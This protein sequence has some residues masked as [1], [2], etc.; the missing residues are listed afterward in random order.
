MRRLQ[1]IACSICK[2]R[3]EPRGNKQV[4]CSL[5]CKKRIDYKKAKEKVKKYFIK[6]ISPNKARAHTRNKALAIYDERTITYDS[7]TG[8]AY[9]G[10]A[11]RPLMKVDEGYGFKGV[12]LQTD[13]RELVQCHICG[14]WAKVIS[15]NHLKKHKTNRLEYNAKFGLQDSTKLVCDASSY[16]YEA[17]AR[18]N[19]LPN[20]MKKLAMTDQKSAMQAR[21]R[22]KQV[23]KP[24]HDNKYGLCP[25]QLGI[26]LAQYITEYKMLPSEGIK[27]EGRR[28]ARGLKKRHDSINNGFKYYFV[29]TIYRKGSSVELQSPDGEQFFFNYNRGYNREFVY[30][31]IEQHC[32]IQDKI[33]ELAL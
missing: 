16:R 29:P 26:R 20:Q 30:G 31:W 9:V 7:P 11:K 10:L 12:L 27:G 19:P 32:K 17:S 15:S 21:K 3:F 14:K 33:K 18:K 22:V 24:E 25:L 6:E 8:K 2:K 4:T 23:G 1:P 13:N 28:I 5:E